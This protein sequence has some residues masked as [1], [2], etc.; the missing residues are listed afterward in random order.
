MHASWH[1]FQQRWLSYLANIFALAAGL[2][3]FI[4]AMGYVAYQSNF[5]QW[6]PNHQ[7]KYQY[8]LEHFDANTGKPDAIFTPSGVKRVKNERFPEIKS[9]AFVQFYTGKYPTLTDK[10][11][12]HDITL[13][14]GTA[15]ILEFF[16][17][18]LLSG[19]TEIVDKNLASIAI[20]KTKAKKLFGDDSPLNQIIELS[21]NG[22]SIEKARIVAI[23]DDIRSD[24]H[25]KFDVIQ[26]LP[27]GES[28]GSQ[29]YDLR[30]SVSYLEFVEG[31]DPNMVIDAINLSLQ[32]NDEIRQKK[33]GASDS[34]S[35]KFTITPITKL[36]HINIGKNHR[37]LLIALTV[38]SIL[39]LS[40]A[41]INYSGFMLILTTYKMK[42][43]ALR[44]TFALKNRFILLPF[45]LETLW[46]LMLAIGIAIAAV[47]VINQHYLHFLMANFNLADA[48]DSGLS[49]WLLAT[50]LLVITFS[51]AL[52][53]WAALKT[54]PA[55]L[56]SGTNNIGGQNSL[57]LP[58]YVA[59]QMVI[60]VC[61]VCITI[62]VYSQTRYQSVLD[63]SFKQNNILTIRPTQ[64][65]SA[66]LED[67]LRQ[68]PG[69]T[70]VAKS[71][72]VPVMD[73]LSTSRT[74]QIATIDQNFLDLY[75]ITP[76]TGHALQ[77]SDHTQAYAYLTAFYEWIK[78]NRSK[79]NTR[80]TSVD[81]IYQNYP[82][83]NMPSHFNLLISKATVATLGLAQ[84]S[85][86]VGHTFNGSFFHKFNRN[87][88]TVVGVIP[89]LYHDWQVGQK[90]APQFY[91]AFPGTKDFQTIFSIHWQG[92][93]RAEFV[94][95]VKAIT[96]D[97]A[98]EIRSVE[99]TWLAKDITA[100]LA[101]QTNRMTLLISLT[102]LVVLIAALGLHFA[103]NATTD[104]MRR[105]MSIRKVFGSDKLS[106]LKR[107]YFSF[108]KPI[109][110]AN[111]IAWPVAYLALQTWLEQYND[112]INLSVW[113]FGAATAVSILVLVLVV[114]KEAFRQ[115]YS[116]PIDDL[117][118]DEE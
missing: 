29:Y 7:T 65:M 49:R 44:K 2:S 103:V 1:S 53:I 87:T 48:L 67:K 15:S 113:L 41:V 85:D 109:L 64:G 43:I 59:M 74:Y 80:I 116:M 88:Y 25:L 4:L 26:L 22:N 115:A 106:V 112:R 31:S 30:N 3:F 10:N 118:A 46:C 60:A 6:V 99:F 27:Y 72:H 78:N 55:A 18:A 19:N 108:A 77:E 101:P 62:G 20:A 104:R 82:H 8:L 47:Y 97:H 69:V 114:S 28:L 56:F 45:V 94:N 37:Y 63:F 24:S 75:Q 92:E 57:L 33:S 58:S 13:I 9:H 105:E 51:L 84:A 16:G 89:D 12:A 5:D 17:L 61:I 68:L 36:H 11:I 95:T 102:L 107:V 96:A 14:A 100:K 42:E 83:N 52:P 93:D 39:L 71:T 34:F 90:P 79:I 70:R 86:A 40:V 35:R 50:L 81:D 21:N 98:Q 91:Q 32:K 110:I 66:G 23:F 73:T 38:L 76:L 117:M 111:F 54:T